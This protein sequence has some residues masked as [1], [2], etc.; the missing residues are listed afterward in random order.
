M[1][2]CWKRLE[3]F[4][5]VFCVLKKKPKCFSPKPFSKTLSLAWWECLVSIPAGTSQRCQTPVT[6]WVTPTLGLPWWWLSCKESTCQARDVGS[7]P[8]SGRSNGGGNGN[9]L[10]YSCL[11]SLTDRRAWWAIQSMGSQKSQTWLRDWTTTFMHVVFVNFPSLPFFFP[12][13]FLYRMCYGG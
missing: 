12:I 13:L 3:R 4:A 1:P 11:G 2:K 7:I 8:G 5:V 9:P 10:Q 6:K